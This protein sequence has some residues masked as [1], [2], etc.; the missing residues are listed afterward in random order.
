[1]L[2]TQSLTRSIQRELNSFYQKITSG[3]FSIQHVT[4]GAFT[5]ARA[6]LKPEAFKE[7]NQIGNAS[8]YK[9]APYY[10]WQDYR[11][12]AIDGS[13][14]MLPKHSS[15]E[16]EFGLV[17]FGPQANVPR[18][19]ATLSMLYDVLNFTTLDVE[20]ASYRASE[21]ELALRHL[22][23]VE[24]GRDLLLFDRGYPSL[25]FMFELK[26][27]GIDFCIRM[28]DHW[29]L[30]VR[31]MIALGEKDKTVT[32]KLPVKHR[33][34][35]SRYNTSDDAITCRLAIIELN[36]GTKEVLCT[37]V[38]SDK[39]PYE[40]LGAL[41]HCRWG[42]E[43]GYKLYKCRAQLEIFSGKTAKAVKQDIFAKVFM[44]STMAILA[45]PI[46]EKIRQESANSPR[47]HPHKINRT[48]ALAMVKEICSAVFIKKVT[49]KALQ[50]FDQILA[51]TTEIIRPNRRFERRKIK[52]KP[53]A[54]NY[55][56]L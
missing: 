14:V 47:K 9:N 44:M 12:L 36:D 40:S 2:L 13:T 4:K 39:L 54:M 15:I 30:E 22:S 55:K 27:K 5:Q 6:K 18:S 34:L 17:E 8:F 33:Q 35:L 20:L 29:W 28:Q 21:K 24:P 53:P 42:I 45:F 26:A 46:E 3:D 23:Y 52:K 19:V 56:H 43:E 50:A 48:N 32:F 41:Y 25:S 49:R 10:M 11:L 16:E 37:S 31:Q 7:L 1:M 51:S 38:S